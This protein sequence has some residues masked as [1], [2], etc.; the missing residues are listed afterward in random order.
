[1]LIG[2][3][4][5]G[6]DAPGMN[7]V[8]AAACEEVERRGGR[9]LGVRGGFGGLASRHAEPIDARQAR[10][11]AHEPGTWLGTSRWALLREPEGRA[12]CREAID[13]LGLTGLLVIGGDGSAKG[14]RALVRCRARRRRARHD[15]P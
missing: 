2:I 9:A 5:S 12:A 8:I 14:A 7:A 6:G 15:R 4:T 10:N 3:L 13:A 1:M 11:H